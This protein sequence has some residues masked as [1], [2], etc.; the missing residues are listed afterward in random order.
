MSGVTPRRDPSQRYRAAGYVIETSTHGP[1][2]CLGVVLMSR[3]PQGG[4]LPLVGWR[5]DD[6]EAESQLGTTWARAVVVGTFD[7]ARFTL[8]ERPVDM[9]R[10]VE[11]RPVPAFSPACADP[12]GDAGFTEITNGI[13]HPEVCAVW[14]SDASDAPGRRVLNVVA[15]PRAGDDVRAAV[16]RVYGGLLCVVE[17]EQPTRD[18][19]HALQS[20]IDL[21]TEGT[22][23]GGLF[24]SHADELRGVV[25]LHV[26][27]ADEVSVH[28]ARQ[29]WGVGVVLEGALE[30]VA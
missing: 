20:T 22:P 8:T 26:A 15:R 29:R 14:W 4:G 28:W 27:L 6:V 23:F 5:W 18:D 7:G 19:L 1:Q 12:D 21:R 24:G 25:V 10:M 2:L 11:R 3:P 30:P 9:D 16:R 13:E 17:R